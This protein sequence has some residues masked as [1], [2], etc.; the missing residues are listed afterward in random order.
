[1]PVAKIRASWPY[2]LYA[3]MS[4]LFCAP[5]FT[6]PNGLGIH[7]W[8]QHL[9][10]Y[11]SVIKSVVEY[12]QFPFWNP[13]YCGGNV[14]W[15]NP[16]V[17]ILSPV[18]PLTTIVSLSLAMK[19]NIVLHYWLG[20]VGMHLLLTSVVG[21]SFL[22]VVVYLAAA[23]TLMGA[24]AMHL[25][26]G[27][28]VFLPCFYLPL[29][30][31]FFFRA[32][33]TGRIRDGACA[34]ALLALMVYNGALHAVP[35][36]VGAIGLFAVFAAGLRR[37]W[38]PLFV[39]G[40]IVAAGFA[41]AAPKLLPV[42]LFVT[43]DRF[44][45][46]RT[47][48]GHPDAMSVEMVLRSYLDPYQDRSLKFDPQRHGWYEYG[49]YIGVL[50]ALLIVSSIL[51]ILMSRRS[52]DRWFGLSLA[53]TSVVLL[54]LSM[55]EFAS[56]APASLAT[57]VPLFSSFR[58]PSRYTIAFA[59]LGA[60]TV[61]WAIRALE[62]EASLTPPLK[63]FLTIV[64]VLASA[65]LLLR[66]R[67]QLEEVF[68]NPP[69]NAAFH[70]LKGP[71][72]LPTDA[73]TSPYTAN[74]PMLRVLMADRSFFNCYESLQVIPS[75]D[76]VHPIVF[77]DDKSKLLST[78]F[79]PNRIEFSVVGGPEASQVLRN[80]NFALGWRSSA[81]EVTRNGPNGHPAVTLQPGQTGRFTFSFVPPGLIWGAVLLLAAAAATVWGWTRQFPG[82][83]AVYTEAP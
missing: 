55:G 39:A 75:A 14:L 66:N 13:W 57:H 32:L 10:Y 77:T 8:D 36:S 62:V 17:P 11:A 81:G 21:L 76:P 43:S 4:A 67:L 29:Q 82:T 68:S 30:L 46:A 23:A 35:M 47:V 53:F 28:S 26:V 80:E 3:L 33:K 9:F 7:D 50:A 27:H 72:D 16:Q 25:A 61:G 44:L 70:P 45:D 40:A 60:T 49:N 6:S 54:L 2:A 37:H 20:F 59:I 73:E 31:Y 41:Y 65:D 78:S 64:C 38:Q 51:W 18:F 63:T 19:L 48:T 71:H 1:M 83:T 34:A 79:T 24:P 74:A 69:L 56:F 52:R 42:A 12:G 5:I 15:Q 58:I 22:P